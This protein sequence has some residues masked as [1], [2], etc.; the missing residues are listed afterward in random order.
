MGNNVFNT[1]NRT[2]NSIKTSFWGVLRSVVEILLAFVYRT[3]F[4]KVLGADYLGLNGLFTNILQVLSL[5]EL[6]VTTAIVFRFYKP[7]SDNNFI[8]VGKLMNYLK[9]VYIYIAIFIL[10]VGL[11]ISPFIKFFIS[12]TSIVPADINLYFIYIL[13]LI[14]TVSSYLF[15]YKQ[16]IL[17]ADQRGY[18]I[19]LFGILMSLI[20]YVVQIILL[21]FYK[22]YTATLFAGIL[23][24]VIFNFLF[25]FWTEK[26]YKFVFNVKE[27]LSKEDKTEIFNDTKAVMFHKVG[28]TV[29]LSTDSI[30]LSKYVS[31]VS[32]GI[33]S[34]YSMIISG[35]QTIIGMLLGN[36]VSSVGN[37][38]VKLSKEDNYNIYKKLLFI[39]F[40]ISTVVIVCSY[41]LINDFINLWIGPDFLFDRFTLIM[42]CVQ[43]YIFI[44]RQINIS[45]TNGC[46]LFTKD[47]YR[48]I[49]EAVLNLIISIIGVKILGI[50]GVF[51]GTVISSIATVF[52]REPVILYKEEFKKPVYKYWLLYFKFAVFSIF[53][54]FSGDYIKSRYLTIDSILSLVIE[55]IVCFVFVNLLLVLLYHKKEEYAYMKQLFKKIINKISKKN[56]TYIK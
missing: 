5:A 52:W 17:S 2:D 10:V 47:R 8:R 53:L 51:I 27:E 19:S 3:I 29:K 38:H 46:G 40:W 14:N 13:Y 18:I 37:A 48:P 43:F 21:L 34:N 55:A 7:I 11:L 30:I 25:S 24:S 6:G 33:Y 35:L 20:K 26:K 31:L 39:N 22:N 54:C 50:V 45:Y 36:F 12:D 16:S 15:V 4:I 42:L 32:A 9:K 23:I 49:I 1:N 28:A 44:S 41:L 56:Y